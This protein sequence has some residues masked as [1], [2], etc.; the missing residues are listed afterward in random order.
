MCIPSFLH[1][2]LNDNDDDDDN[3]YSNSICSTGSSNS[4]EEIRSRLEELV[5]IDL[6]ER[7]RRKS[8]GD[9]QLSSKGQNLSK[10]KSKELNSLVKAPAVHRLPS[11]ANVHATNNSNNNSNKRKVYIY[12]TCVC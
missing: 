6:H 9:L 11:L 1:S 12:I 7:R 4:M 5:K 8:I 10:L 3:K 2:Q